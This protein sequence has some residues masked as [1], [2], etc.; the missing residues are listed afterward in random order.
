L[1]ANWRDQARQPVLLRWTF[2]GTEGLLP[3]RTLSTKENDAGGDDHKGCSRRPASKN[4][5]DCRKG[6]CVLRGYGENQSGCV[7]SC[8]GG[9]TFVIG[10]SSNYASRPSGFYLARCVYRVGIPLYPASP[11]CIFCRDP[12]SPESDFLKCPTGRIAQN[13]RAR[14]SDGT[15]PLRHQE[16]SIWMRFRPF[17]PEVVTAQF[18]RDFP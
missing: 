6:F 3:Q 11:A 18:R 8:H 4:N 12:N 14:K 2:S 7:P 10:V 5:A 15:I 13:C 1:R 17:Q 16:A 9:L